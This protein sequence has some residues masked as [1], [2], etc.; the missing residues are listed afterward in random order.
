MTL[1]ADAS[2]VTVVGI[3]SGGGPY[4]ESFRKVDGKNLFRFDSPHIVV[5]KAEG[6]EDQN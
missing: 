4:I 5:S 3:A 1:N 6:Q 2:A